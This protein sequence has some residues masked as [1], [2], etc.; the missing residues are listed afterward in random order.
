MLSILVPGLVNRASVTTS[1][2]SPTRTTAALQSWANVANIHFT[3]VST[4][5]EA[6][7]VDFVCGP[8]DMSDPAILGTHETP[9]DA[10]ATDGTAWG[11][12]NIEADP[13]GTLQVGGS[14]FITLVHELGHALGLA[15]LHDSG[16]GSSIFPGVTSPGDL[17]DNNLNQGIFTT[18]S[19]NAGWNTIGRSASDF[20]GWQKGPMA[21][22]IAAIQYLYGANTTF[23]S[24]N[25]Q[26]QHIDG[27]GDGLSCI[28]DAGGTD[29]IN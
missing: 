28:W 29:S 26:L 4:Y 23:N 17:G 13:P 25:N 2:Q 1:P 27:F 19:Y 8:A 9:Q 18:M 16:G 7:L 22:D 11:V 24:G 14:N 20:G 15:H 6:N 5:S 12:F 3:E 10:N 21:F